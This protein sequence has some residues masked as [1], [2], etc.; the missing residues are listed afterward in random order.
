MD[1]YLS[2]GT[3][4]KTP[5]HSIVYE[6]KEIVGAGASCVVYYA[7]SVDAN[8]IR[9]EHLLKEYNPRGL[10]L[11]RDE[12]LCLRVCSECDEAAFKAGLDRFMSGCRMQAE[13]RLSLETKNS[14]SNIQGV[15][16]TNGTCYNV[17]TVMAGKT[18]D[19][20]EEKTLYDLLQRIKA[21]T[22]VVRSY[23][24][25]GLLHLDIKPDNIWILPETVEMVQMFDFDS[26]IKKTD[27]A[28][29]AFLSYTQSWAAPEQL[30]PYRRN[31]ICEATDL[32]AIGE[33][34]FNKL[35]GRHSETHERRSFSEITFDYS[36]KLFEG[37]NPRVFPLLSEILKHTI[38]KVVEKRYQ[39]ADELLKKLDEAISLANPHA[40]FLLHHL[41]SKAAFFIGRDGELQQIDQ[42]LRE[43][44]KLF[45]SSIGGMGKSELAKQYAYA[46][47]DE[48]DAVIF[49]VCT[50]ALESMILDDLPVANLRRFPEE[51][52]RDYFV[53]KYRV[54]SQLCSNQ[55]VLIIVD[56]FNDV[57]DNALG[58]L[59]QLNCKILFTTRH[60][61][62]EYNYEQL[63]LGTL[64]EK[65][66]WELFLKWYTRP[67]D[68]EDHA[69]VQQI[70]DLYQNHTMAVELIAKQ[71][72]ASRVRPKKM[73]ARLNEGGFSD[74][75]RERVVHAKDG[76]NTKMT[77]YDHIRR[78]FDV[79][80]LSE[81]QVYV[82]VNLA[83]IPPTGI[84]AT[85]FHDWCNLD[86]YEAIND[87]TE[88]G[89]IREEDSNHISLHP[90]IAD[91]M[92]D[93]LENDFLICESMLSN[94]I[95]N[96]KKLDM[97]YQHSNVPV[98]EF[99]K[100]ATSICALLRNIAPIPKLFIDFVCAVYGR[101]YGFGYV[102]EHILHM[103]EIIDACMNQ[104]NLSQVQFAHL[105]ETIAILYY[106]SDQYDLALE[107]NKKALSCRLEVYGEHHSQTATSYNNLGVVYSAMGLFDQS[108]YFHTKS[109]NIRLDIHGPNHEITAT[110]YNNLG[111]L[112]RELGKIDEAKT[113]CQ[114]A[115][116]IRTEVC[117]INHSSTAA[118]FNNLGRIFDEI[119]Q[120]DKAEEYYGKALSIWLNVFG[121]N[122]IYTAD[123]Y[124]NLGVV[125]VQLKKLD[126]AEKN[127]SIA[128][129]IR[130]TLLG[131]DHSSVA[132]S[133][134]NLGAMYKERLMFKQA[135]EHYNRAL[136][137]WSDTYGEDHYK[138][139]IIYNNLGNLYNKMGLFQ[140]AQKYYEKALSILCKCYGEDHIRTAD[141]YWSNGIFYHSK[142]R[143]QE[144]EYSYLKALSIWT[145]TY[146]Y[147]SPLPA[148]AYYTLGGLYK[149]LGKIG[150][151][152]IMHQ[153]ALD[154]K[155]SIDGSNV[156]SIALS[157]NHL[158]SLYSNSS[159]YE[160]ADFHYSKALEMR[161]VLYGDD[162]PSVANVYQNIGVL[163]RNKQQ[164]SISLH[165]LL[166]ALEIYQ[167]VVGEQ[168]TDTAACY[169]ALG[170]TYA[171]L[172]EYDSA[173][174]YYKKSLS[175]RSKLYPD[176]HELIQ[177][178]RQRM[179]ELQEL[180]RNSQ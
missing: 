151:A 64:G 154:I 137:I 165:Y 107:F 72:Q 96:A 99:V 100:I 81:E 22:K 104:E 55:R 87:L 117:G 37:V 41:P 108:L 148:K 85:Q 39:C 40:P 101:L 164:H 174:T 156:E 139:V 178:V 10:R 6:I 3:Q 68:A 97:V 8:G 20:V 140:N 155:T 131:E 49:C 69:A 84:N 89:W 16:P 35:M 113:Y 115:L 91:I 150:K 161:R 14:T 27:V 136:T 166:K 146:G 29:S 135:E 45:V 121:Q 5:D 158:G 43:V 144:A 90:V 38:C 78:L 134:I 86:S 58:K 120:Y 13:V 114:K 66:V 163:Y 36:N 98:R 143:Y 176:D 92:R 110:S 62:T 44:D 149:S 128:L 125:R 116:N 126:E 129:Q 111:M 79:S 57:Q 9:T 94:I 63:H 42:R 53:R 75:G 52:S 133:H 118:S 171:E 112:Y 76:M 172:Q 152:I 73:L 122:H 179:D 147:Q 60:D 19:K 175:I 153:K 28:T 80:D 132:L 12:Q 24:L 138:L 32:F 4:L 123:A 26:V 170:K 145:A 7:D 106:S 119:K 51:K 74:S 130:R 167:K 31:Q 95:S 18:Y 2:R 21:I 177:L 56:N 15:F 67:L 1:R 59:L 160:L 169:N 46:H 105:Y 11:E 162:H 47:K 34:L 61:V 109:L 159:Q 23:H 48:Y 17:M 65:H 180:R 82:L 102:E 70:F 33:I 142:H 88:S 50:M 93:E 77:I 103:R 173:E 168:H 71:M 83:L 157:H 30:L 124:N 127:H 25:N 141:S 54:L